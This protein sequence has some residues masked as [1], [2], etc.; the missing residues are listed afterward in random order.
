LRQSILL[1]QTAAG[2]MY[3]APRPV[4]IARAIAG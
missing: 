3:T 2:I 4:Q 1:H